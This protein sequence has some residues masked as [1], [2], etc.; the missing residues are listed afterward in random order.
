MP[1][2]P[3]DGPEPAAKDYFGADQFHDRIWV[4]CESCDAPYYI[5][6]TIKV[7]ESFVENDP[8]TGDRPYL[9]FDELPGP[10][11]VCGV[12]IGK[13]VGTWEEAVTAVKAIRNNTA[14]YLN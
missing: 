1:E 13:P 2:V 6:E 3:W 14:N 8:A 5:V 12:E 7:A 10:C 11:A 4:N 9:A